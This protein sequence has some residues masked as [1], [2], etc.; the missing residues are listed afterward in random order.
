VL[1]IGLLA[2]FASSVDVDVLAPDRPDDA[3]VAEGEGTE[4]VDG[5][6]EPA[7]DDGWIFSL[8][9]VHEIELTVDD[10]AWAS[11]SADPYTE[12]QAMLSFDG[13]ELPDPVGIRVKGRLG[14]YRSLSQ[15][16]AFKVDLN[17]YADQDLEGLERLNLNNQVQDHAKVHEITAYSLYEAAGVWAPRVAYAWVTVNGDTFGLYSLVEAYD[18]VF[19]DQRYEDGS[20]NFYDGDYVLWDDGSY[21]QLDFES[22]LHD[23]FQLDEG[24]DVGLA[25]IHGVTAARELGQ[26][27]AYVEAL[28][29]VLD[30]DQFLRFWALEMWTGQYDGYV[31]NRNNFRV[32]F[33]PS[34]GQ[35]NF[36]PWDH[37]WAFYDTTPIQSPW[38]SLAENCKADAVCHAR[39]LEA[40]AEVSAVA[41]STALTEQAATA[42]ALIEPFL[43]VDPRLEV[44]LDT[45]IS[46]QDH[47]DSWLANRSASLAGRTDL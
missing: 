23:L 7:H 20:G 21:T 5:P 12:V 39:F 47:L 1:V 19:L 34:T 29:G 45:I 8:D 15:K 17:E 41:D 30:V 35:A 27:G 16:T 28:G 18:D 31:Y 3:A 36:H 6:G 22:S 10:L 4:S 44:S 11:L 33:D 46:Y 43:R 42:A 25:D 24:V 38:G 9:V 32:Y 26:A 40:L 13:D 37:D 14:S 2:C